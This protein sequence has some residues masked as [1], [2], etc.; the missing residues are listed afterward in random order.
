MD[1]S[2]LAKYRVIHNSL[3]HFIKSV[4]WNDGKNGCMDSPAD[5][6]EEFAAG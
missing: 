3:T 1:I 4:H 2:V 5:A 6:C